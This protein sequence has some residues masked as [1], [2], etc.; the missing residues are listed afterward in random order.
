MSL[1]EGLLIVIV[2]VLTI[3]LVKTSLATV[4]AIPEIK[5]WEC[6]NKKNGDTAT[7]K[8]QEITKQSPERNSIQENAEFFSGQLMTGDPMDDTHIQ[9]YTQ[10][11]YGN[12]ADYKDYVTSQAVDRQ[13]MQNHQSFI[14][15]R[16]ANNLQ[17]TT[18]KTYAMGEMESADLVP[19]VGIKGR[20]QNIPD[21]ASSGALQVSDG[22]NVNSYKNKPT[23]T[24]NSS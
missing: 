21:S 3:C 24:W 14:Q 22:V 1:T 2:I 16:F 6:I 13:V 18:G 8:I 7:V 12:G 15:D 17:N 5:S 4:A 20:P 11:S 23:F 19:W 10:A 9:S